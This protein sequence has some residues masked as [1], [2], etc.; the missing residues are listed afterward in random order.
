MGCSPLGSHRRKELCDKAGTPTTGNK[1]TLV[2]R[3][4]DPTKNQRKVAKPSGI[5]KKKKPKA[6]PKPKKKSAPKKYSF[7]GGGG[8]HA[9]L[10]AMEGYDDSEDYDS[11]DGRDEC[12]LCGNFDYID[13]HNGLCGG[14]PRSGP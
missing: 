12:E 6:A 8:G 9:A 1:T 7:F 2:A 11:E 3:L 10:F 14:V 13:P 5:A 4:L